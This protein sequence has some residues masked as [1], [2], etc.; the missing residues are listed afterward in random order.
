M[1]NQAT[2]DML[3]AMK[4][5]AMAAEFANQL[6]DPTFNELGFEERLGLLV[7]AEWNRRQSNKLNRFIRNARFAVP[8][9]TVEGIEYYEDRKLDK[10]QILRF[11]TG[12]YID[13]GHHIILKGASGNGKTYIACALGNAACRRFKKVQYIR[14]PELLD[15]LSIARS[16]GTLKKVLE[17]YK[18]KDLLILDEWLI[19]PLSPQESYDMLEIVEARCHKSTIFCTQYESEGWYTRIDPNPESDSPVSEAIMD[20]I[21]HNAYEVLVDGRVSMRERKGLKLLGKAVARMC[22]RPYLCDEEKCMVLELERAC[23]NELE[24]ESMEYFYAAEKELQR[25][26]ER[27]RQ[28][29]NILTENGIPV[30]EES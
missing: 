20:R 12:Q 25:Q 4:L 16:G 6:K 13:E 29:E 28:L 30:P 11:A 14:M 8:S 1:L 21:I 7:N 27:I 23:Y 5:T 17:A 18:K 19:R 26:R 22:D 9:A 24:R 3:T 15:E 10:A 2:M